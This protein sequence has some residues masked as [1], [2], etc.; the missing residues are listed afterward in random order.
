[1][2]AGVGFKLTAGLHHALRRTAPDTGF[3]E[4]GFLNVLA[5]TARAVAGD[6]PSTVATVLGHREA[7]PLLAILAEADPREVRR[8]FTSFGSCSI[9]DPVSDLRSLG[10]IEA[11]EAS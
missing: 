11:E 5:A 9:S 10:L 2:R 3:E 6:E 4:H 8:R 1:M 7:A